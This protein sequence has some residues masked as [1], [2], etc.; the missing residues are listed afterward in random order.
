MT[1]QISVFEAAGGE[2]FFLDLVDRFYEGVLDDPILAP[3]Y[4]PEDLDGAKQRLAQFLVQFF[5]GPDTYSEQRG[6]PRLRMRHFPF[7]VDT[8]ARDAW[9]HHMGAALESMDTHEVVKDMMGE[10]FDHTADLMRNVDER[11]L[12]SD[13]TS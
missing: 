10:Y 13:S 12:S 4:P 6:H 5:G 2:Q 1:E 9:L 3:M 11:D 7:H 8:A